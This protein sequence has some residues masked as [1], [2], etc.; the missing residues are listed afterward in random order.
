TA[1]TREHGERSF[2]MIKDL[3]AMYPV[4]DPVDQ[5]HWISLS[6]LPALSEEEESI[7]QQ[8]LKV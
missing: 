7:Q 8:D 4:L 6:W 3:V 1:G 5:S 2:Q